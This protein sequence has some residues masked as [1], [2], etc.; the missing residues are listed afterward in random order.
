[1]ASGAMAQGKQLIMPLS[2]EQLTEIKAR[3]LRQLDV[4]ALLLIEE[5]ERLQG[6]NKYVQ[7]IEWCRPYAG[8]TCGINELLSKGE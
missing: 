5:I 7:H 1:M 2:S 8:C 3:K 4:D 6:L